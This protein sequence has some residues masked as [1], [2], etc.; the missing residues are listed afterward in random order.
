MHTHTHDPKSPAQ[1]EGR[2]IR[3]A[4]FYDVSVNIM[5]L[6]QVSRLRRMTVDQAML[7]PSESIL[8]IGC[9][10]A[11]VTIPAKLQVGKMEARQ[12]RH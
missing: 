1:T 3:W 6:G 5:T 11:G 2:L 8:D 7:K 9:G 10:T 12:A 4:S